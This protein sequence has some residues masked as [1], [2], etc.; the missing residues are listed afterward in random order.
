MGERGEERRMWILKEE[1]MGDVARR[2][3][4]ARE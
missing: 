1:D 3:D 4:R 2:G